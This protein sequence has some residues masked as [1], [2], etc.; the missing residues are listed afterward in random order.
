[1]P[2]IVY[3]SNAIR[4]A[5]LAR[6]AAGTGFGDGTIYA[7]A[8]SAV[9]DQDT[10]T[11]TLTGVTRIADLGADANDQ[12]NGYVL[13]FPASGNVYHI[14]DYVAPAGSPLSAPVVTVWEIPDLA[15]VTACH[16]RRTVWEPNAAAANPALNAADGVRSTPWQ[17]RAAN[18][19]M[20]LEVC[21]P[22]LVGQGG[23][24]EIAV[25]A[26][27]S[28]VQAKGL[29]WSAS[30]FTVASALALLGS[31]M[32][33]FTVPGSGDEDLQQRMVGS[34]RKGRT[35][36]ILMKC[37]AVTGSTAAGGLAVRVRNHLSGADV[38]ADLDTDGKWDV[39]SITTTAAWQQTTFVPDF[40]TDDGKLMITAVFANRGSATVIRIDEVYVWDIVN[41]AALLAFDHNWDGTNPSAGDL[42]VYRQYCST[43]RAGIAGGT[44]YVAI[45]NAG[46]VKGTAPWL[47]AGTATAAPI[48][49]LLSLGTSGLTYQVGELLLC[50][51][52]TLARGFPLP[53]ER[54]PTKYR[55]TIQ[56]TV[57]G[58]RRIY[59][60]HQMRQFEATMP[61]VDAADL[62]I[63][64]GPF[65]RHHI[66]RRD[67]FAVRLG[68]EDD[69]L[70]MQEVGEE[71]AGEQSAQRPDRTVKWHEVL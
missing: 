52:W 23:F 19:R 24:E 60:Y 55:Q 66:D 44:E 16:L 15:D 7:T 21:L 13:Y 70:L 45:I 26:L 68:S 53:A 5:E 42:V 12:F 67:C 37:Q 54:G 1:M 33:S 40:D 48:Y 10:S 63:W 62:L 3:H 43:S 22:N 61:I 14:L 39:P 29:W 2:P 27:P 34:L 32:C 4:L 41:V 69:L 25:G 58:A 64:D 35:Y 20:E 59:R 71:F 38:D 51:K 47:V 49:R 9:P 36:G 6:P 65:R 50:E 31:R 11:F 28:T 17:Q 18:T 57:S 30:G 8:T 56:E 46:A